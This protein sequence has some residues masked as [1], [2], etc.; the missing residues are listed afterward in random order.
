M[1]PFPGYGRHYAQVAQYVF[2][3]KAKL[4]KPS[5]MLDVLLLEVRAVGGNLSS[6]GFLDFSFFPLQSIGNTVQFINLVLQL[7]VARAQR[8]LALL[9]LCDFNLRLVLL[10]T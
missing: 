7:I 4:T 5:A 10:R 1:L 9:H 3:I 6:A 8:T 2:Q